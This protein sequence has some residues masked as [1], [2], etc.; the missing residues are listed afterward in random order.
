MVPLFLDVDGPL[1][2]FG[3][4]DRTFPVHGPPPAPAVGH[5][6][7]SRVDPALGPV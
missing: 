6:L 4:A 3:A 1:L 5:P 2:P 7:L